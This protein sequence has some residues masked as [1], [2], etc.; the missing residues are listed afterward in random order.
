MLWPIFAIVSGSSACT[1]LL[2]TNPVR[3]WQ[4]T[5]PEAYAPATKPY[6]TLSTIGGAPENYLEAVPGIDQG[7]V[8]V[9]VFGDTPASARNVAIAIRNAIEPSAHMIST[10]TSLYEPDT[11]LYRWILEFDFWTPR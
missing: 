8:Q 1:T 4:D 7:R 3:F 10:P 6:A 11:K 5:V 2:G 9:D